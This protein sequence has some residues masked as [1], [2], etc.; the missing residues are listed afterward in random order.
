MQRTPNETV[1]YLEEVS[2]QRQSLFAHER[3]VVPETRR[4][5]RHVVVHQ[6]RV[7]TTNKTITHNRTT[8]VVYLQKIKPSHTTKPHC[9]VFVQVI[10]NKMPLKD[11]LLACVA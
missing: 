7:P 5:I 11:A 10:R 3:R 2:E 9:V 8:R 4:D 1:W 6:G